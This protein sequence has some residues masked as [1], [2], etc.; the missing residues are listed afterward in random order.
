MFELIVFQNRMDQLDFPKQQQTAL[1]MLRDFM[2]I[3]S[4]TIIEHDDL[5]FGDAIFNDEF[6][7]AM[8]R[9]KREKKI[10]SLENL[11]HDI[12]MQVPKGVF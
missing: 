5:V 9:Y 12:K 10:V 3:T 2:I 4:I 11:D 8:F 1:D 7:L 6:D